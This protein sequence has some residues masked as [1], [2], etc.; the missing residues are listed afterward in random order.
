VG[1]QNQ[2][3]TREENTKSDRERIR[4]FAADGSRL[5]GLH[6]MRNEEFAARFPGATAK[7]FDSFSRWVGRD[8]AGALKPAVRV[9]DYK[10]SGSK[11]KCD[12]RCL[13]ATG[14]VMNCECSCGGK[15]HGR[16]QFT[17]EVAA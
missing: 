8:E 10:V 12:A 3:A 9:I 4:Y 5:S 14:R 16:G 2:T 6:G 7:R 17:C 11:H 15:N 1:E 13:N